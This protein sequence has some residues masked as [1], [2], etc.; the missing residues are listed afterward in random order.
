M[1]TTLCSALATAV[2][3]SRSRVCSLTSLR[4]FTSRRKDVV[5]AG[6]G[7]SHT[8]Q[9]TPQQHPQR[10]YSGLPA[11]D[12]ALDEDEQFREYVPQPYNPETPLVPAEQQQLLQVGVVGAPNAGKSTLTNSLVGTKASLRLQH[13]IW[14]AFLS[15]LC[16][17]W[18]CLV[19]IGPTC[20]DNCTGTA[21]RAV[22]VVTVLCASSGSASWLHVTLLPGFCLC[23][24][25]SSVS[26]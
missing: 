25:Y 19:S 22:I 20:E 11:W 24:S 13:A 9:T 26:H 5:W 17:L 16:S 2:G 21:K 15:C 1:G 6:H 10:V 23:S 3:G 8:R 12:D 4:D 7:L 14:H 18:L